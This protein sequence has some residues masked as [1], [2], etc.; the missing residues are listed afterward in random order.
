MRA[1]IIDDE[2]KSL[3]TLGSLVH[4]YAPEIEIIGE[5]GSA[6]RAIEVIRETD[7]DLVFLD[8]LMPDGTGFDVLEQF[9][10]R[11]FKFIFVTAFDEHSLRAFRYGAL[12]YLLKPVNFHDLKAA[13]AR[14][15]NGQAHTIAESAPQ[16]KTARGAYNNNVPQNIVLSSVEGFSV[17]RV[18]DIVRCEADANYTRV[19]FSQDK[20]FLAS[21][22][23]GHFEELLADAGFVRVHHKH[24]INLSCVKRY[25]KGRGGYVEMSD[26]QQ[27]EVSVRKKD[28][29]LSALSGFVQG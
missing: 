10:E 1:V 7:P 13:V 18:R 4:R 16:L 29:F 27:I 14:A 26:G 8:I 6:Q 21:K 3:R 28:E 15:G 9:P 22:G 25:L 19:Y 5:A 2:E 17:V 11:N 24:L 20:P 23:L 12:H